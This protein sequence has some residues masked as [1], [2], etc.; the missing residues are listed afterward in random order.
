MLLINTM[1]KEELIETI[2]NNPDKILEV[3]HK[4]VAVPSLVLLFVIMDMIFLIVGMIFVKRDRTKYFWIWLMSSIL[5]GTVLL[6]IYLL[7]N[8]V[9]DIVSML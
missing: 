6:G 1:V 3:T 7:P 2:E 4:L 9:Q 5:S 8:V